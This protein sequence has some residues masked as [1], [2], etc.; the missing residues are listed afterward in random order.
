VV[1]YSMNLKHLAA[2]AL[3]T[4]VLSGCVSKMSDGSGTAMSASNDPVMLK[5]GNTSLIGHM[6][7]IRGRS[8]KGQSI[9]WSYRDTQQ[10][11]ASDGSLTCSTPLNSRWVGSEGTFGG[12]SY[13]TKISCS[14]GTEG[15]MRISV[16]ISDYNFSS[17]IGIGKL[18]N[19]KKLSLTFGPSESEIAN[20]RQQQAARGQALG[21]VLDT[22]G[23]V[24]SGASSNT[25]TTCN[26][27][28]DGFYSSTTCY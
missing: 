6:T 22:L 20:I 12:K 16:N 11:E 13:N 28:S 8:P 17:G 7:S 21:G 19:G 14:D 4:L 9:I 25:S 15:E 10:F 3:T 24:S 1:N 5:V 23:D 2:I 26:T 27:T 18:S